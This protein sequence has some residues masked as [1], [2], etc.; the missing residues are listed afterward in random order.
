MVIS[1]VFATNYATNNMQLKITVMSLSYLMCKFNNLFLSPH[2]TSM[3][4]YKYDL[5]L[6]SSYMQTQPYEMHQMTV[7]VQKMP[8][9]NNNIDIENQNSIYNNL[10]L[11]K[12]KLI[13]F[14][15]HIFYVLLRIML[16]IYMFE[17][18]QT[19]QTLNF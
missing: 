13:K 2:L 1:W 10:C 19:V 14:S 9:Q 6:E 3:G 12:K 11:T 15:W 17:Y 4:V 8:Y 18:C 16:N 5:L 7:Y